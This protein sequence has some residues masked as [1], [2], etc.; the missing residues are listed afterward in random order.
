MFSSAAEIFTQSL[1]RQSDFVARWG[2]EEFAILLPNTTSEGALDVAG[3]I[4]EH[5]ENAV[6]PL[7]DGSNTKITVSI[8][9]NTQIP[10]QSSLLEFFIASADEALYASKKTG[11]NRVTFYE[12]DK[13]PDCISKS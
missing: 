7:P 6:I 8:G 3:L 9:V 12:P 2:G 5:V 13:M 11:R 1:K 4:R 10:T